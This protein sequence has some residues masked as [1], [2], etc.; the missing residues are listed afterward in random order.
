MCFFEDLCIQ[1]VSRKDT[2]LEATGEELIER[3]INRERG[4][5]CRRGELGKHALHHI[6]VD[7]SDSC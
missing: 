2:S 7:Q 3:G 6:Q 4:G 1:L 5:R